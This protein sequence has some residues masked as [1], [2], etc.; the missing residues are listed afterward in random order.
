MQMKT[1]LHFK[2]KRQNER[3]ILFILMLTSL[4]GIIDLVKMPALKYTMDVAWVF[5]LIT[6]ALNRFRVPGKELKSSFNCIWIFLVITW[7][8]FIINSV[9]IKYYLWGFR[10]NFRFFVFFLACI[11][12]LDA[13]DIGDYM[14]LLNKL[15]YLHFAVAMIQY[16]VF[17]INQ[18]CL[19]GIFGTQDGNNGFSLLFMLIIVTYSLL[20][21]LARREKLVTFAVKGIMAMLIAAYSELKVFFVMYILIVVLSLLFTN[22]SFKKLLI[23]GLAIVGI[24]VGVDL[25]VKVFPDWAG[26]FTWDAI[27]DM[28]GS[29]DG[30]TGG[31]DLNRLTAIPTVW[32]RFLNTR[33]SQLFGLG[34]GNCDNASFSFL[35][36]PFY[37]R[38]NHLHYNWFSSS[39]TLLET[40]LLGFG[41]YILFFVM[42]FRGA[43][44]RQ[45]NKGAE[46]IYC[47][48]AKVMSVV[49]I[50]LII[51]NSSMRTESGYM[52]YFILALPFIGSRRKQMQ[53]IK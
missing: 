43:A 39:F 33:S 49:S 50:A 42:T 46:N 1:I 24:S 38:Y 48:L 45:K 17:G 47:Q 14:R 12:F 32:T 35:I 5:L 34:L 44:K 21:Y 30:Y 27:M 22:F 41:V 37:E 8:G 31:G 9:P 11:K 23:M 36:T 52:M 29:S 13:E 18:D 6:L 2:K 7:I 28:A 53:A 51:Y 3:A 16:Y 26:W 15:F 4:F 19:G 25:L 10:N 40:G 20:G